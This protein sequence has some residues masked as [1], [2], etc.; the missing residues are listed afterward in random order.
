MSAWKL[1]GPDYG[2]L[3]SLAFVPTR[4]T[5]PGSP[6]MDTNMATISLFWET[7]MAHL[8]SLSFVCVSFCLHLT[9]IPARR[10]FFPTQARFLCLPLCLKQHIAGARN[11]VFLFC[12]YRL[13]T[14]IYKH[15]VHR[16]GFK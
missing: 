13:K 10:W 3:R 8:T 4:L 9:L 11:R 7:N 12:H 15:V 6:R 1:L 5:A 2:L 14:E 16:E